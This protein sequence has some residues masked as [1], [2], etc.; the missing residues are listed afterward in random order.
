MST[1]L[2]QAV[3]PPLRGQR[4]LDVGAGSGVQSLHLLRTG[5]SVVATDVSA[6]AC[7]FARVTAALTG[8]DALGRVGR[9]RRPRRAAEPPTGGRCGRAGAA[10]ARPGAVDPRTVHLVDTR[11][12]GRVVAASTAL[13]GLVGARDGELTVAQV[14]GALAQ[15]LEV[16]E[17]TR[18][19]Q[20][21]PAVRD[22][23][24][25]GLLVLP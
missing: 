18:R 23:V 10:R 20:L 21:L 19:A 8:H 17:P 7:P 6:R 14:V 13:A 9:P 2:V 11:R 3:I 16:D 15:L 4:C 12:C 5:G 25:E 1:T 24:A 22:L